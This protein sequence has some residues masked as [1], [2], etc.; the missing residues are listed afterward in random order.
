MGFTFSLFI[1]VSLHLD[2][3]RQATMMTLVM[4]KILLKRCSKGMVDLAVGV[5][6]TEALDVVALG[7][8]MLGAAALDLEGMLMRVLVIE[9]HAKVKTCTKNMLAMSPMTTV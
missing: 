5:S 6:F 8:G 4:I 1:T 2:I 9:E 7:I 3:G